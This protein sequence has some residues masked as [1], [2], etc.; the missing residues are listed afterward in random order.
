MSVRALV[1]FTALA[2]CAACAPPTGSDCGPSRGVVARVVDGDTIE[3]ESGERIRYLLVDTPEST[4]STECFGEEA[5]AFN[6]SIVEG[7]EVGLSYDIECRDRFDRLLAYVT[8]GDRDVNALLVERGYACVL[9][10]APNGA[11]RRDA[12]EALEAAAQAS[13]AGH[14]G[15]CSESPC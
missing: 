14:W 11:E 9:F 6:A 8:V 1:A 15:A 12:Y 3:L 4:T 7:E 2:V 13:G 5:R 10:I